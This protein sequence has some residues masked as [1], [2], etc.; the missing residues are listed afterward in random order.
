MDFISQIH[1]RG[2]ETRCALA[3][4]TSTRSRRGEVA[5]DPASN[6]TKTE[7][8][9]AKTG[10]G[11][12][13]GH[14]RLRQGGTLIVTIMFLTAMAS[15]TSTACRRGNAEANAPSSAAETGAGTS[16][17]RKLPQ[18]RGITVELAADQDA[19]AAAD[20][21][22]AADRNEV[23]ADRNGTSAN[24]GSGSGS[25]S[26]KTSSAADAEATAFSQ[27]GRNRKRQWTSRPED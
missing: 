3:S 24:Q 9:T 6:P 18:E 25:G 23:V 11:S 22:P 8:K 4:L 7:T 5:A 15:P 1:I 27:R 13:A 19:A 26:S 21:G 20:Q 17:Q 16:E 10:S 2:K 14:Q 12:T